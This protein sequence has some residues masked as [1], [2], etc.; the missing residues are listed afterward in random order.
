M[1]EEILNELKQIA[2]ALNE[3]AGELKRLQAPQ[4]YVPAAPP[5]NPNAWP[6][7]PPNTQPWTPYYGPTCVHQADPLLDRNVTL[8]PTAGHQQ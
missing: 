3:I 4:Y 7:T 5:Y 2:K 1:N 6:L 8:L